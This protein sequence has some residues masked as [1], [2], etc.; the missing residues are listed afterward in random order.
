ML[1]SQH[2]KVCMK[3]YGQLENIDPIH[4][5]SCFKIFFFKNGLDLK[6]FLFSQKFGGEN[7]LPWQP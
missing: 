6:I 2:E 7:M 3:I 1:P 5:D 4:V